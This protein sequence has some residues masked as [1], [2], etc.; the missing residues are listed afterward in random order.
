MLSTAI[1]RFFSTPASTAANA[2]FEA[3]PGAIAAICSAATNSALWTGAGRPR[4]GNV[5]V[6]AIATLRKSPTSSSRISLSR[7]ALS[8]RR[9]AMTAR[10]NLTI[11]SRPALCSA[12]SSARSLSV[13]PSTKA[14][15]ARLKGPLVVLAARANSLGVLSSRIINKRCSAVKRGAAATSSPGGNRIGRNRSAIEPTRRAMSGSAPRKIVVAAAIAVA[16][17]VNRN[18]R[19]AAANGR[20]SPRDADGTAKDRAPVTLLM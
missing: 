10:A 2:I 5:A 14:S 1:A 16:S 6:Q 12:P 8:L 11:G 15:A 20:N 3:N 9:W 13:G 18:V 4:A 7:R 19:S 17:V